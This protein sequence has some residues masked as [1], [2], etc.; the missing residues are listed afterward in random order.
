MK[1]IDESYNSFDKPQKKI[2]LEAK[3][4]SSDGTIQAIPL[5]EIKYR[6]ITGEVILIPECLQKI[7]FFEEIKE[8]TL[9][10]IQQAVGDEKAFNV[11]KKGF[12][13]IHEI[14]DV[15]DITLVSDYVYGTIRTLAPNLAKA[16]VNKVFRQKAVFFFEKE[17]N[18]RFHVPYDTTERF[19]KEL[20]Q[21]HWNGKITA[22]GPHHDSWYQ[23]PTNSINVWIAVGPVQIGNSLNIYPQIYGKRLPCTKDG[24]I[25]PNQY[26]GQG[27]S[28]NL[29][30]GDALIFHGEHLHSSEINSTEK[31]RYVV[32]LRMTLDK[33][34]FLEESPYEKNYIYSESEEGLW[35]SLKERFLQLLQR[36]R[37]RF[38]QFSRQENTNYILTENTA[39]NLVFDDTSASFPQSIK[40]NCVEDG[41]GS[42]DNLVFDVSNLPSQHIR[43][44]SEKYCVA[45]LSNHRV[46]VFSRFCT[47]EG[48]DLAG[49]FLRDDKVVCPWH[50]LP[51]D[52]ENGASPCK[53]LACLKILN[54]DEINGQIRIP[55]QHETRKKGS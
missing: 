34:Q 24:K 25:L 17:P 31:T 43:A 45:R 1:I 16:I 35:F 30:P 11:Q 32:S 13:L 33:P 8:A 9:K 55:Q 15:E 39:K 52:L 26:Y 10:G 46:V 38:N 23:C 48:A 42:E 36:L 22:H 47:H 12:E 18:V 29:A 5:D 7:G 40:A 44:I 28:F 20:N 3:S 6:V 53:S 4:V 19:R 37:V 21:F 51:F 14:V 27:I 49:G 50:T 2:D 54:F 41:L